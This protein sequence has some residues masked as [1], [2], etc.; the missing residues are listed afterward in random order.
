MPLMVDE[1]MAVTHVVRE[2][3][4]TAKGCWKLTKSF[5]DRLQ[6]WN[7][8]NTTENGECQGDSNTS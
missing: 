7:L 6:P 8:T 4:F 3:W 5:L 1:V 2:Y